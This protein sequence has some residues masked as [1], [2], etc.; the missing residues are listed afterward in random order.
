MPKMVIIADDLTGATDSAA[1]CAEYGL[2]TIVSLDKPDGD[3]PEPESAEVVAI[4]GKTRSLAADQ[5]AAVTARLV[6][7]YGH[8]GA[9]ADQALLFK[10]VDSTLRGHLGVELAAALQ[11]RRD[12]ALSGKRVVVLL[13]PAFP[14]QGRTT[15]HGRQRL[16]GM[17]LEEADFGWDEAVRPRSNIAGIVGDAGLSCGIVEL[18]MVRSGSRSLE[19][20]MVRLAEDLDVI[21]CDAETD[22]DLQAIAASSMALGPQ[23]VWAGSAGL[24]RH[25]P[26]GAGFAH[27]PGRDIRLISDFAHASGPILFVVGSLS[28]ASREQAQALAAAPNVE[29][30]ANPQ[31]NLLK[32]ENARREYAGSVSK[33]LERGNDV[34]LTL[35]SIEQFT[36]HQIRLLT[37]SLARMLQTLASRVGALVATGGETARAVLDAWGIRRLRLLGEVEPGLPC[38]ITEGWSRDI[39]VLT[40]AGG[41]G[42]R[43]TL[44]RCREFLQDIDRRQSPIARRNTVVENQ[45]N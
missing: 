11:A 4:D 3:N 34:L 41:F 27:V 38:S 36:T 26:R 10:K 39:L 29:T 17:L 12:Q 21:V 8:A 20:A 7:R 42:S 5:A 32:N 40:K 1:A 44:L 19:T 30:F 2:E 25:L 13:S 37:A 18:A 22:A 45:E 23:T 9:T 35:N 15:L 16:N 14:S 28:D 33:S 31:R 24:A 6:Q 43:E